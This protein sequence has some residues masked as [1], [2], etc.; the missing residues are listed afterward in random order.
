MPVEH[1]LHFASVDFYR[2]KR[3]VPKTIQV[4]FNQTVHRDGK[5]LVV[6]ENHKLESGEPFPK[7]NR[8]KL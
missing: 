8:N 1:E 4:E 6:I 7:R 2:L 3:R 5:R